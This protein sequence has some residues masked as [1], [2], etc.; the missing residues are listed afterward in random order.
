[1][2]RKLKGKVWRVR[3]VITVGFG[4]FLF[5]SWKVE[6]GNQIQKLVKKK[7]EKKRES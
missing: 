1:M 6:E 4:N 7:W 5:G 3:R 2:L